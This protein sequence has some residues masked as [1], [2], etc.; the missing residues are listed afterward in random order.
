MSTKKSLMAEA[1]ALR[2]ALISAGN[3]G[4]QKFMCFS[5]NAIIIRV[6]SL[7]MQITEVFGIVKDIKNISSVFI[8]T[9]FYHF[10]HSLNV[11]ADCLVKQ[12]LAS[13]LLLDLILG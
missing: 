6:I 1:L 11:E 13:S 4:L 12:S 3:L 9:N 10:S 8:E 2:S 5:N 7:D